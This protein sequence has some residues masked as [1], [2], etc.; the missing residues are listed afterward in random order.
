VR[1][2]LTIATSARPQVRDPYPGGDV[3]PAS[4]FTRDADTR[5]T[6]FSAPLRDRPL[7]IDFNDAVEGVITERSDVN[8]T[9]E[10]SVDEIIARHQ[11][12]Q[13]AQDAA[14]RSYSAAVRMEQH[15]RPS[16][17][18]AGYDIVTENRF[19][20]DDES[21]EWEEL[22]FS[23]NGATWKANRPA[24]PLLQPEKVLS[25]PLKLRLT[26]E[27]RYRLD[28][29]Q[30]VDGHECY[31]VHFEPL[32]GQRS[33]YR[34]TVWIDTASFVRRKLQTV[35][36]QLTAPIVSNDETHEFTEV[37]AIDGHPILLP[38][39]MTAKQ[40]LLIAGR[41]V[42]LEKTTTFAEYQINATGFLEGRATA[43]SSDRIMYRDTDHGVRYL[44][45][46]GPGQQR[47]VSERLTARAKALAMGTNIDPSYDFPLPIFGINYL[48][49]NFR[50]PDSQLAILFAG[51]LALGNIQKPK[52]FG[53]KLDGSLDFFGIAVPSNDRIYDEVGN[54]KQ[55]ELLT[56]PESVGANLGY[57]FTSFQK[58]T[59]QY[60]FQ[61]N[62]YLKNRETTADYHV[63]SSTVTHGVGLAYEYR[64]AGYS[65]T[66]NGTWYGRM[67]WEPWGQADNLQTTPRTYEKYSLNVSKDLFFG[68]FSK[69][70]MNGAYFGGNGLDRFSKYQFGMFDD[71]RV[72]GVPAAGVRYAEMAM[73]RGS[74]SFNLFEQ[75]RF[76]LF[77]EQAFGR[78]KDVSRT[79]DP[80][81][82]LGV[83]F[84][85]KAPFNT[86]LRA[87]VGKAFLPDRYRATGST[88][89]SVLFL[90]PL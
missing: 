37:Q 44:V 1:V 54:R 77:L 34:G 11:Q 6:T 74:Y 26:A 61:F 60:Q 76:D 13:A 47:V 27:Y 52:L 85:V 87:D 35:Q 84:T 21:V 81:T 69:I 70:H 4:A 43:R 24:F 15:F 58:I 29:R 49:F 2:S 78:D 12:T 30:R 8:A 75:Y 72:H 57:Q 45:K 68:L 3:K 88:V 73:A 71:T 17:A 83:A 33:M 9:A 25:V 79:F 5:R 10:L 31:V 36:T 67:R 90:K 80:I 46:E 41:N 66:A 65:V 19:F 82:G 7:V 16:A 40:L 23:V 63:P 59:G 48:D 64:R 86:L 50:G 18:D 89:V 32:Q 56:F 62:A 14:V 20:V 55:D 39:R 28:G 51:V 22:S 53:T 38:S 42:L